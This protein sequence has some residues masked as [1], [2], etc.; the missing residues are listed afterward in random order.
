MMVDAFNTGDGFA[1]VHI[2]HLTSTFPIADEV[3]SLVMF[4]ESIMEK[5]QRP[6]LQGQ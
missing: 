6:V 5:W 4:G 1:R 3:M 2:V